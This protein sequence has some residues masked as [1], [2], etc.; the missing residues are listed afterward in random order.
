MLKSKKISLLFVSL[1][2]FF[3]T[4]RV[5]IIINKRIMNK[6]LRFVFMAVLAMSFSSLFA[7]NVTIN[8]N[9]SSTTWTTE[10]DKYSGV[11]GNFKITCSKGTATSLGNAASSISYRANV[12]TRRQYRHADSICEWLP[13]RCRLLAHAPV[14]QTYRYRS[15]HA[16]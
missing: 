8:T 15:R 4:L 9:S 1:M 16:Q 5:L 10:T 3:I 13:D 14:R 6:F 11:I 2:D 12:S 7:T